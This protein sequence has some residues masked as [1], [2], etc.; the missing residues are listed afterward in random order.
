ML[1]ALISILIFVVAGFL[2][3]LY[4]QKHTTQNPAA[5]G[6]R[7]IQDK[8]LI[9]AWSLSAG[10]NQKNQMSHFDYGGSNRDITTAEAKQLLLE[11]WDI[12]SKAD[13]EAAVGELGQG[14]M[15]NA[16]FIQQY[17]NLFSISQ[18]EL[19]LAARQDPFVNE[20]ISHKDNV[21]KHGII[22]W[23]MVRAQWIIAIAY[24]AG[25]FTLDEARQLA[26]PLA[27]KTQSTF[28]S[29]EEMANNHALGFY[30][31]SQNPQQYEE[32]KAIA[33]QL[34]TDSNS[35][36]VVLDWNLNLSQK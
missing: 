19:E 12:T 21:V 18:P 17:G 16:E 28:S 36:W 25:Y 31:W 22:A 8:P 13:A 2:G 6:T 9:W 20:L 27:I 15:H 7:D 30:F 3:Y 26:L 24:K 5:P 29:W 32:T 35:P 34:L 4:Y 23:D 1:K 14:K 11:W 33:E 10:L